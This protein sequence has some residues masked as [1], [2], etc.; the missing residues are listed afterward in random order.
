MSLNLVYTTKLEAQDG[1]TRAIEY[2]NW[3]SNIELVLSPYRE[4][5]ICAVIRGERRPSASGSTNGATTSKDSTSVR[6]DQDA[7]NSAMTLQRWE[8]ASSRLPGCLDM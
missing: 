2:A 4:D 1:R 5:D 7:N 8:R 6:H 3:A